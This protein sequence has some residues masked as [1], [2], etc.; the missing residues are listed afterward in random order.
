MNDNNKHGLIEE[1]RQTLGDDFDEALV[2][3]YDETFNYND[4]ERVFLE[5]L[6]HQAGK[7]NE[8]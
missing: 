1:F 7:E 4:L 5:Q 8:T 3:A 2:K 6:F